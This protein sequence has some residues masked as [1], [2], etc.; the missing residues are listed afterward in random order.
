MLGPATFVVFVPYEIKQL[1]FQNSATKLTVDS[2]SILVDTDN[3]A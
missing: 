2:D 1:Y 3:M